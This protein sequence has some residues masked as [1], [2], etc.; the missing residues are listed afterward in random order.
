MDA[1]A[2]SFVTD[3]VLCSALRTAVNALRV[4]DDDTRHAAACAAVKEENARVAALHTQEVEEQ[5]AKVCACVCV[6][7]CDCDWV[8]VCVWR[9]S[10]RP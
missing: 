7:L 5:A 9:Y 3:V 4:A 1:Y 10:W 2:S 8:C 6:C